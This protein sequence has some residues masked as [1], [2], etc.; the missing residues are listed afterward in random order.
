LSFR[1]IRCSRNAV[2]ALASGIVAAAIA[3]GCAGKPEP[4][5]ISRLDKQTTITPR[6]NFYL[7]RKKRMATTNAK[8][9]DEKI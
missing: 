7:N 6:R 2:F 4:E 8:N 3:F 9:R 5:R 1:N